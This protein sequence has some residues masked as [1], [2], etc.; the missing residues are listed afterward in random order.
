MHQA[1]IDIS[2]E[3]A[4]FLVKSVVGIHI[5]KGDYLNCDNRRWIGIVDFADQIREAKRVITSHNFNQPVKIVAFSNGPVDC[6]FDK[7]F[8]GSEAG[9]T[10]CELETLKLMSM[11]DWLVTANSTYSIFAAYLGQKMR[12]ASLP[13]RYANVR[14]D[15]S[16]SLIGPRMVLY[17]NRLV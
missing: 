13:M 14:H 12:G 6:P 9:G 11:C 7:L 17:D 15:L 4:A 5:R 1:P 16:T 3:D 10:H 8:L 2:R